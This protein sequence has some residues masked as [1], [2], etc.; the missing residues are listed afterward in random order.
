[1]GA[2]LLAF[3]GDRGTVYSFFSGSCFEKV[4]NQGITVSFPHVIKGLR[5]MW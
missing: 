5:F 3:T 1:M 4:Q 2:I